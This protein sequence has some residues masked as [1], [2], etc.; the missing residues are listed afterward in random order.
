MGVG[1]CAVKPSSASTHLH[2]LATLPETRVAEGWLQ[3]PMSDGAE[4]RCMPAT[5]SADGNMLQEMDSL[6][7]QLAALRARE[8]STGTKQLDTLKLELQLETLEA[9]QKAAAV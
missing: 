1:A 9:K 8:A 3:T 5:Q 4:G 2:P 7:A 6:R